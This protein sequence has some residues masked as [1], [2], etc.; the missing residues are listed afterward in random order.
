VPEGSPRHTSDAGNCMVAETR[1]KHEHAGT[2][3][4]HENCRFPS[5][6][7][8]VNFKMGIR[9][10]IS[11]IT[12]SFAGNKPAISGFKIAEVREPH[13]EPHHRKRQS[14]ESSMTGSNSTLVADDYEHETVNWIAGVGDVCSGTF[15]GGHIQNDCLTVRRSQDDT[16]APAKSHHFQHSSN[17]KRSAL[18][19]HCDFWD[20]DHDGLIYPWDIFI[21]FRKLGFNIALCLWAA[22]TMAICSSYAT[23]TSW[24]P[25]PM[26]AINLNNIHCSRHGSTTGA[27]DLDEELDTRRFD[28]I[29]DKYAGGKDY[30]TWRTLYQ[31][32]SGQ[33]VAND[34]FGWFAGGLEWIAMYILLWPED[35]KMY[36]EEIRGVY[37]GS[38][39]WKIAEDRSGMQKRQASDSF[40]VGQ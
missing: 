13:E 25:H 3:K 5:S 15:R 6:L 40:V 11:S 30:L 7:S 21:G 17:T 12:A 31:I 32:W 37:D 36:K 28:A 35:G 27:Y 10:I 4:C 23:Q 33:C 38:I 2:N 26:F 34:W 14:R 29:F 39:F 20:A 18:R 9:I 16:N 1:N 8:P 22:V 24:L 19:R